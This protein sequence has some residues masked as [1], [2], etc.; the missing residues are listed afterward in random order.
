MTPETPSQSR[1]GSMP[2]S[3]PIIGGVIAALVFLY[4]FSGTTGF[5]FT[6]MTGA[7]ELAAVAIVVIAAGGLAWP[8]VSRLAPPAMPRLFVAISAAAL[9]LWG[10][11]I[12]MLLGG[13]LGLMHSWLWWGLMVAGLLAAGY[14]AR[15][16]FAQRREDSRVDARSLVWVVCGAAI[17]MWLAGTLRPPGYTGMGGDAYDVLVYHLQLPREFFAAGQIVQLKHNVYSHYPLGMEMLSLLAMCLRGGAYEGMYLAKAFHGAFGALAVLGLLF[18]LRDDEDI[19]GRIA[20]VLLATYAPL[21]YLSWLAFAEL[22][23]ICYLTLGLIWLRYWLRESRPKTAIGIGAMLGAAC[24]FKY[25]SVGFVA[26]PVLVVMLLCVPGNGRRLMD[27]LL[28]AAVTL[29]LFSPWLIRNTILTGNPVFPLATSLFGQ[30]YWTDLQAQRWRAGHA[31]GA[32]PPVPQVP[33]WQAPEN[34]PTAGEAFWQTFVKSSLFNVL[35]SLIAV[36]SFSAVLSVRKVTRKHPWELAL[37]AV[38]AMQLIVWTFTRGMPWRFITPAAVPIVLLAAWGLARLA[39][40]KYNPLK[41]NAAEKGDPPG[42]GRVACVTTLVALL[43]SNVVTVVTVQKA[44]QPK[45]V[46]PWPGEGIAQ[47]E[48]GFFEL[49]PEDSRIAAIGD[50][51]AFYYPIDTVYA[52]AFDPHPLAM[53]DATPKALRSRADERGIT[54]LFV[55]WWEIWRLGATYGLPPAFTEGLYERWQQGLPPTLPLIETLG[56]QPV[57][58]LQETPEGLVAIQGSTSDPAAPR[59]ESDVWKPSRPPRGWPMA[60]LYA[61]PPAN[62]PADWQ[63][64]PLILK[65]PEEQ[66]APPP[67]T[68]PAPATQPGQATPPEAASPTN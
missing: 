31:P 34:P 13:S 56:A 35:I 1:F 26:G 16:R 65:L 64:E 51:A 49:L 17:G 66:Q 8:V 19:R 41:K 61:L 25:L 62:A 30:G 58:L 38:L 4:A 59:P 5:V 7:L 3:A 6:A 53:P 18:G 45:P 46:P 50:A 12:L 60:T 48:Y 37:L 2:A 21:V 47:R 57:P 40:V 15:D 14:A 44:S 10:L 63:P 27:L 11:S 68:Q 43:I 55:N 42:W 52:T 32:H 22:S 9:G 24:A 20:G 36:I 28:A 54:H 29:A 33:G 39:E 23:M 67:T